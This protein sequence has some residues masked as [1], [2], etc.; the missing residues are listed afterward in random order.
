[1]NALAT[2]SLRSGYALRG[3][4]RQ[5]RLFALLDATGFDGLADMLAGAGLDHCSLFFGD[6]AVMLRDEAPWLVALPADR[7]ADWAEVLRRARVG[8]AGF[9]CVTDAG[10][11]ELR[12]HWKKW[13]SV[14]IPGEEGLVLFRFFDA[15]IALA[16]L[17]AVGPAD[18]QAFLGPNDRL[19]VPRGG[20][21]VELQPALPVPPTR[22]GAG[23]AYVMTPAQMEAFSGV[24][25]DA[26]RD[27]F[28][29]YMRDIWPDETRAMDDDALDD[30]AG[31]AVA[32][33][34]DLGI[35]PQADVVVKLSL[36]EMVTPQVL[37]RAE[38]LIAQV[39]DKVPPAGYA[40]ILLAVAVATLPEER[41]EMMKARTAWWRSYE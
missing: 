26:F 5:G 17:G 11:D 29:R 9:L 18:A 22:L 2:R 19:L 6:D 36:I 41:G 3:A 24:A 13:L 12:R 16:F 35:T 34:L 14:H 8:H 37:P 4:L 30:M 21:L 28:R 10:L 40:N 7:I 15:R 20:A 25:A 33:A 38:S 32:R 27:R 1:V 23:R 31:R 39:R